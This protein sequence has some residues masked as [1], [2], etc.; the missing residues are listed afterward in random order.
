[1]PAIT[2]EIDRQTYRRQV[3]QATAE[4]RPIAWQ[5]EIELRRALESAKTAGTELIVA[6]SANRDAVPA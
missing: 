4:R 2:L 1:M 6:G 5:A 3:D